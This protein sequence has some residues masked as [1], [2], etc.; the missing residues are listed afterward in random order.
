MDVSD[1]V[2]TAGMDEDEV[3]E[4]LRSG[5]TGVL[6]LAN[7]N[8]AYAIPVSYR[9]DGESIR[10]RLGN[11]GDSRKLAFAEATEQACFVRYGVDGPLDSWS[12]LVEGPIRELPP[13]A[14]AASDRE[15]LEEEYDPLRVFDEAVEETELTAYDLQIGRMTGR[16]TTE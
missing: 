5:N 9:Y 15:E 10:F 8:D 14:W 16:R 3:D 12:I 6:A 13:E 7:G 1:Y 4:R 11:D 2:Y